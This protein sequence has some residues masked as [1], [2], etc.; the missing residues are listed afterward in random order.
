MTDI[1]VL[2]VKRGESGENMY[3]K[4]K[5][6]IIDNLI[7]LMLSLAVSICYVL[8]DFTCSPK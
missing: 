2:V 7:P 6:V 1:I 3:S 8:L 5:K 4:L